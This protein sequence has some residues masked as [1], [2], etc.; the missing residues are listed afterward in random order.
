MLL[1]VVALEGITVSV[2]L[3]ACFWFGGFLVCGQMQVCLCRAPRITGLFCGTC[4]ALSL[5]TSCLPELERLCRWVMLND[6][7]CMYIFWS[8]LVSWSMLFGLIWK[9][10]SYGNYCGVPTVQRLRCPPVTIYI[11]IFIALAYQVLG[12]FIE[13]IW[14]G[15]AELVFLSPIPSIHLV[16]VYWCKSYGTFLGHVG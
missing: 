12:T 13:L 16:L 15:S 5:C 11:S 9:W 1:Y 3:V 10:E 2:P 7:R 4:S 6:M 14:Y 8:S